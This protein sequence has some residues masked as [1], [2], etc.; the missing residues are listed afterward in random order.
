MSPDVQPFE[1][2]SA[3]WGL[4]S[5]ERRPQPRG[6]IDTPYTPNNGLGLRDGGTQ[7]IQLA[8]C[9][10]VLYPGPGSENPPLCS[11][12]GGEPIGRKGR[13]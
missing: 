13:A 10:R 7:G 2:R 11:C 4:R 9:Q 12:R 8:T 6:P 3:T 5:I 1:S